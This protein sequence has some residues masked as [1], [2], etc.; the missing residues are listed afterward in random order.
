MN[1]DL[2]DKAEALYDSLADPMGVLCG[3]FTTEEVNELE[4]N[5][6]AYFL[7][8]IVAKKL[9]EEYEAITDIGKLMLHEK[10]VKDSVFW[11][12]TL[13]G[14][15]EEAI[16]LWQ[17]LG[18]DISRV[19]Y[20]E[21]LGL[22]W[23]LLNKSR[24]DYR[25]LMEQR[26]QGSEQD[27]HGEVFT[28]FSLYSHLQSVSSSVISQCL[29]EVFN[30]LYEASRLREAYKEEN[31]GRYLFDTFH[32][33]DILHEQNWGELL[34]HEDVS[35]G[36]IIKYI[37]ETGLSAKDVKHTSYA[38]L[39]ILYR[40][41][42]YCINS[43][44]KIDG[45]ECIPWALEDS[46]V[47]NDDVPEAYRE[48]YDA[49]ISRL[50]FNKAD[51]SYLQAVNLLE[52]STLIHEPQVADTVVENFSAF[53]SI[54]QGVY[55]NAGL[56]AKDAPNVPSS[57][58]Y[59]SAIREFLIEGRD[60]DDNIIAAPENILR[61]F[62]TYCAVD[63]DVIVTSLGRLLSSNQSSCYHA[64]YLII[65]NTR[66]FKTYLSMLNV[67]SYKSNNDIQGKVK[68]SLISAL[69]KEA[70]YRLNYYR[71]W[72]AIWGGVWGY[73][74]ISNSALMFLWLFP[75]VNC[76]HQCADAQLIISHNMAKFSVQPKEP[77]DNVHPGLAL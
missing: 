35:Y 30:S 3:Q 64:L 31:V 55:L 41:Q 19:M 76:M 34:T 47:N 73:F 43:A 68:S 39:D 54:R 56:Y 38:L 74:W 8:V 11:L 63:Y 75:L 42:G 44:I 62:L 71:V 46:E 32:I 15:E 22:H 49:Q 14:Y 6:L 12:F 51:L 23:F 1:K 28:G 10:H 48:A 72:T 52:F 18:N 59:D 26:L 5:N 4:A 77:N 17:Y 9:P 21:Q 69:N 36:D 33:V 40:K 67:D 13:Q 16:N 7:A 60:F 65:N 66:D 61:V 2:K 70:C 27:N 24:E 20:R 50:S 58:K 25:L 37:K 57:F 45:W 53:D 29:P